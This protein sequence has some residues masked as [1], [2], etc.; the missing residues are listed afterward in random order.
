ME[1]HTEVYP[2]PATVPLYVFLHICKIL[3]DSILTSTDCIN[4]HAQGEFE[5]GENSPIHLGS[6]FFC[7]SCPSV[8]LGTFYFPTISW[9]FPHDPQ[10]IKADDRSHITQAPEHC[11]VTNKCM[12]GCTCS[13]VHLGTLRGNPRE[14]YARPPKELTILKDAVQAENIHNL[15][16]RLL[17]Y[18]GGEY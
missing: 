9:P 13:W 15:C 6:F 1:T 4:N 3:C 12:V 2:F 10:S 16:T 8:Q 5:K 14:A 17:N 11:Q 7:E 18:K